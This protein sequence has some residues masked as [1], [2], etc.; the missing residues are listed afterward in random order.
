KNEHWFSKTPYGDLELTINL[1]KPEK[2]PVAIAA[3][4]N[5]KAASYPV[6]LLCK[7]NVGY[8]GRVDHPARQNHRM[9]PVELNGEQWFLQFSP[10]VYYN[11]H[12]IV[13]SAKH[14]PM[15]ISKAG[16]DRLLAFVEQFPHYFVGSNAD[17]P[18]VGGS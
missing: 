10:Y 7:E 18:I 1:S 5:K 16:F 6:C 3:E 11:E 17:L 8:Q 12:A 4:K 14:E 15:K 13:L 2:D 9:I